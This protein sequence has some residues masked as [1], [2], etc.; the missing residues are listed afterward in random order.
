MLANPK[1]EEPL[2]IVTCEHVDSGKWHP[3]LDASSSSWEV[4]L[5]ESL[6]SRHRMWN[7]LKN[8]PSYVLSTWIDR[9]REEWERGVN[10]TYS[11]DESYHQQA[12]LHH[13]RH[14]WPQRFHQE[15]DHRRIT[16]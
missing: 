4:F 16:S 5:S 12:A 13:H 15:Y 8:H 14:P 10:I 9:K 6:T 2:S 1:K 7:T 11:K 3:P